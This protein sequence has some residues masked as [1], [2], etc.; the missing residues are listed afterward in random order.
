[1]LEPFVTKETLQLQP[2]TTLFELCQK[3]GKQVDIKHWR[4]ESLTVASVFVDGELVGNGSS[5]E[6]YIAKL[7]AAKKAL[8]V[9]SDSSESMSN[10]LGPVD[11]SQKSAKH[12]LTELCR[13][14][15][16]SKPAYRYCFFFF[17]NEIGSVN[18]LIFLFPR[19]SW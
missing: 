10:L 16:W 8:Q 1:M 6:K 18:M 15:G 19:N 3:Q 13:T 11:N 14:S 5:E 4:K 17:G 12:Q 9:L 7:M 2:V